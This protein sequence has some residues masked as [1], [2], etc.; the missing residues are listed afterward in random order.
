MRKATENQGRKPLT[1]TEVVA[2]MMG[3]GRGQKLYPFA[4]IY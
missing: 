3:K 1:I 2:V 4:Y